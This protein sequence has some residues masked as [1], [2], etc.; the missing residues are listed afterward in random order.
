MTKLCISC[1]IPKDENLHVEA[2]EGHEVLAGNTQEQ[3]L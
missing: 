1:M 2:V 3:K